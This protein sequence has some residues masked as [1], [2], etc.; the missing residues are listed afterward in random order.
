MSSDADDTY[1]IEV[2]IPTWARTLSVDFRGEQEPE[3]T[4]EAAP[5]FPRG[6]WLGFE[7]CA[8][9]EGFWPW[10]QEHGAIGCRFQTLGFHNDPARGRG[11]PAIVH[12]G[13]SNDSDDKVKAA[14]ARRYAEYPATFGVHLWDERAW[15]D[16][17]WFWYNHICKTYPTWKIFR[18]PFE[19]T[20]LHAPG[21]YN[22][23]DGII[24]YKNLTRPARTTL[25]WTHQRALK[26]WY[27]RPVAYS[28]NPLDS[29]EEML[30]ADRNKYATAMHGVAQAF[31]A[32]FVWRATSLWS[33]DT[34]GAP[35]CPNPE[36]LP[37]I[38][39]TLHCVPTWQTET[40]EERQSLP[41]R[42]VEPGEYG[43][44][45]PWK[46]D[47]TLACARCRVAWKA[48]YDPVAS[49]EP[50]ACDPLAPASALYGSNLRRMANW[51]D[52]TVQ[53]QAFVEGQEDALAAQLRD[54]LGG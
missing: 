38:L 30:L 33:I 50:D 17:T 21:F 6:G 26:N 48:G 40:S 5:V 27:G 15:S 45:A 2:E 51:T 23:I 28:V 12:L 9:P 43:T 44:G 4:P 16:K 7:F 47:H 54:K 53:A 36:Q 52:W 35:Q 19:W 46:V 13:P 32:V 14:L 1:G 42:F 37:R 31:D 29:S 3:P 25:D 49:S 20:T 11:F 24:T 34:G 22:D 18:G 10:A 39:T 8:R 41:V